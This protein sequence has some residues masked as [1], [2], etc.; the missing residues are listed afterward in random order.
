MNSAVSVSHQKMFWGYCF[1]LFETSPSVAQDNLKFMIF[2]PQPPKCYITDAHH[3]HT[4][5]FL[6]LFCSLHYTKASEL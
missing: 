5:L 6:S 2:L 3:N 1:V 4:Q